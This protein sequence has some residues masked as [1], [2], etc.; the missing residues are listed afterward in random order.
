MSIKN[1]GK[2]IPSLLK[3]KKEEMFAF[4]EI[5]L[6]KAEDAEKEFGS[7]NASAYTSY[8]E[9]LQDKSI[10]VIHVCTPCLLYK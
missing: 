4:L 9:L 1:S 5:V 8:I 3:A 6:K 2:Y 7:K 10:D